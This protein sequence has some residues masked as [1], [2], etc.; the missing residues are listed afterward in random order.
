VRKIL[1]LSLLVFAYSV[2]WL[3]V[4]SS[5]RADVPTEIKLSEE[6]YRWMLGREYSAFN[7]AF[8]VAKRHGATPGLAQA[9]EAEIRSIFREQAGDRSVV[10]VRKYATTGENSYEGWV[11][12]LDNG[13]IVA[14]K[15]SVYQN[16]ETGNPQILI[17][18]S[19]DADPSNWFKQSW[20][21]RG[22]VLPF[23]AEIATA[24]LDERKFVLGDLKVSG[25]HYE[26]SGMLIDE[27]SRLDP[28]KPLEY[29]KE[30]PG[31]QSF[32]AVYSDRDARP[33]AMNIS[34]LKNYTMTTSRPIVA[35]LDSGVDYNNP[36]LAYKLTHGASTKQHKVVDATVADIDT[37]LKILKY[38]PFSAY[39]T[40]KLTRKKQVV[41]SIFTYGTR[42]WDFIEDDNR[43]YDGA[44]S[45]ELTRASTVASLA[46][47]DGFSTAVLPIR[48]SGTSDFTV[49]E[50]EPDRFED[51]VN[52]AE[53]YGARVVN[54]SFSHYLM[55]DAVAATAYMKMGAP[56]SKINAAV[57]ANKKDRDNF[58]KMVDVM[59]DHPRILFVLAAGN[60][61]QN[62]IGRLNADEEFP[63][64]QGNASIRLP[65]VV[66]V[67][68]VDSTG[69]L[70]TTSVRGKKSVQLAAPGG[71]TD[72]A[73]P[74]VAHA[75]AYLLSRKAN[76]TTEDLVTLLRTSVIKTPGL[77]EET[78]WGGYLNFE[79]LREKY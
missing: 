7:A 37:K 1:I 59:R 63:I 34:R 49:D 56:R 55:S 71:L 25:A 79:S 74:Y 44:Q 8:E 5:A 16:R 60:E 62:S 64:Q 76:L 72:Y 27:F 61:Q 35:V 15:N 70:A 66:V 2:N 28:A 21:T 13:T 78:V 23:R 38:L 51:A 30:N 20:Y 68:A 58:A 24:N 10:A 9:S 46:A 50:S 39:E 54:I 40:G 42:G 6:N 4:G 48:I 36:A 67:A 26:S 19:D 14:V 45:E 18:T 29:E 75:A 3:A 77:K 53:A 33:G 31:Y 73:A 11:V 43:P 41:Q 12:W 32:K 69:R 57:K 17:G 47:G 22:N 52:F 65:N